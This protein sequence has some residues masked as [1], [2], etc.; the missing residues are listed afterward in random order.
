MRKLTAFAATALLAATAG[1]AHAAPGDVN[2]E[3]TYQIAQ[4]TGPGSINNTDQRWFVYG[5]DLGS[6]F[7]HRGRLYM[8]FGDS[9]GPPGKPPEFGEDWRSNLL[10][11]GHDRDPRDGLTLDGMITDRPG[12]AKELVDQPAVPGEE[13]TVIPTYG[14]SDGRRMYLHYM[15][16]REWGP[17]GEWWLNRSGLAYS[18]DDGQTWTVSD[19]VWPG[20]SN[21]GQVAFVE[22]GRHVYLFG[23]PGGR[24]GGVALAR[25]DK[26]ALLD[27]SAYEYWNGSGWGPDQ[28]AAATIVP[29]PVGELSVQWSTHYKKWL[30]MYLNDQTDQVVL[31]TADEMTGPWSDEKTVVTAAEV[32]SVY[33]PYIPPR[34]NHGKDI[35]FALSRFN[36]YDVFWWH[37]SLE[38]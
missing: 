35:Y 16:V 3:D 32:P 10:G 1:A 14:V 18:D 6:M 31:R 25:V 4:L 36:L 2:R 27:A 8:L 12:H 5:T 11:F 24:F 19:M 15:A 7:E 29:A 17:P 28:A 38:E 9:F 13:V 33:A 26:H 22:R 34:F 37:T 30:M 21:F 20:D 23:I